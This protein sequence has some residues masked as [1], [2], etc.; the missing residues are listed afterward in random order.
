MTMMMMTMIM[1]MMNLVV[2]IINEKKR[3]SKTVLCLCMA[4][5]L[6]IY[7]RSFLFFQI[8]IRIKINSFFFVLQCIYSF[9]IFCSCVLCPSFEICVLCA[10]SSIFNTF[11]L[12]TTKNRT[13]CNILFLGSFN[14]IKTKFCVHLFR[15]TFLFLRSSFY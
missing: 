1:G 8:Q 14:F 2:V 9:R 5:T 3:K 6:N 7:A 15:F 11:Q 13:A 12:A 10:S 4:Q